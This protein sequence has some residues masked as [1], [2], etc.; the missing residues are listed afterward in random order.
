MFRKISDADKDIF[1]EMSLEFYN[2][3]A[4]LQPI[5]PKF[6]ENTFSELMRSRDYLECYIIEQESQAAGYCLLNKTYGHEC[7]GPVIWIEELY[8]R[9]QFRGKGLG[10]MMLDYIEQEHPA[11]RYRLET[12]PENERAA[13]LYSRH[14]Y[15]Y[16]PYCQMIKDK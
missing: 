7:G 3:P 8:I 11:S 4:V 12:E 13:S 6:H 5:N 16:L 9:P 1:L 15:I 14:G 2:S 10:S